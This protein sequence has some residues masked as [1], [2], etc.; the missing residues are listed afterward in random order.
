MT[1]PMNII[2]ILQI[3]YFQAGDTFFGHTGL[4][5]TATFVVTGNFDAL[6]ADFR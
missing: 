6:A 3:V 2:I 4:K 5:K 1:H